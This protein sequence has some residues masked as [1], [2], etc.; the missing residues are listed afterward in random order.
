[1]FSW[2]NTQKEGNYEIHFD[3][4]SIAL[5]AVISMGS[6]FAMGAFVAAIDNRLSDQLAVNNCKQPQVQIID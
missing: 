6:N 2:R 5:N 1:M 4:I 3:P